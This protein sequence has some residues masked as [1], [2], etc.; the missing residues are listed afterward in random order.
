MKCRRIFS[1]LAL[2]LLF[3]GT[4]FAVNVRDVVFTTRNT[5]TVVF[6]HGSHMNKPGMTR[7]CRAC[8]DAIYD[9]KK[10]KRH[11]MADMHKGRS[12]GACHDGQKTFSLEECARCHQTREIRYKVKATGPTGFSHK[13]HLA[14]S[15]DCGVCHPSVFAAGHNKRFT[16]ADMEKGRSCGACHN[17]K[18]AFG[19]DACVTCHPV[20]EITFKVKETGPTQFSHKSHLEVAGCAKC[21]PGL[22]APDRKNRRVGMAA[23]AVSIAEARA[24]V[25]IRNPDR[26]GRISP[27]RQIVPVSQT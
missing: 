26:S 22:Y 6:S 25:L 7:N 1:S 16:M 9:L 18:K 23:M 15:A 12:C 14:K 3:Q 21:H 27:R 24:A 5:G 11:T 17:G 8:H 20:E 2:L 10:K 13:A 4:A 19:L